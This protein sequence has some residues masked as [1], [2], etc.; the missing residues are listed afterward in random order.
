[1]I[2][3]DAAM[4]AEPEA[5]AAAPPVPATT[6]ARTPAPPP[7]AAEAARAATARNLTQVFKEMRE[8]VDTGSEEEAAA[9]Q[10]SLAKTYREL[11]MVDDAIEALKTAVR[12]PRQ[13][14]DAACLL[15]TMHVE[16]DELQTAIEWFEHAA[17]APAPA[18][19]AGRGLMYDLAN[20]LEKAG[21]LSR[22]LAVFVELEADSGNY[23]D[24]AYRILRL[25]K[26]Q[27]KE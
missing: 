17:E 26:L 19:A 8:E 22:A 3:L 25:S 6:P 16:R 13:R 11:G 18:P 24:V 23:R 5:F 7:A 1:M 15:G 12:S 27:A 20:T 10:L 2:D 14:F 21:E 9:E 4:F